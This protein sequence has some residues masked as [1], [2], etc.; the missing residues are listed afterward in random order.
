MPNESIF[1]VYCELSGNSLALRKQGR[2][3]AFVTC[4]V[5]SEDIVDAVRRAKIAL[6][7]DEYEIVDI[8]K[9]MRF[10]PE[11]WESDD[12]ITRLAKDMQGDLDV[13]YSSFSSW[14]H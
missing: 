12:E 2:A 3:G 9:A 14:G 1:L 7:E 4:L 10:D 8:E 6:L 11:D 5:P 13:R